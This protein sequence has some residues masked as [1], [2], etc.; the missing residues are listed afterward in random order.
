MEKV[1]RLKELEK[2]AVQVDKKTWYAIHDKHPD[3][4]FKITKG[5]RRK[6]K[7]LHD[8]TKDL[9]EAQAYLKLRANMTVDY[10]EYIAL[11]HSALT[12][13]D[14][15][16]THEAFLGLQKD[17]HDL[18]R[19]ILK[20]GQSQNPALRPYDRTAD[21][22][23]KIYEAIKARPAYQKAKE[24]LDALIK[25]HEEHEQFTNGVKEL[26]KESEKIAGS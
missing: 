8:F 10:T 23:E 11:S 1:P 4:V 21:I 15:Q 16:E 5:L 3:K 20:T 19:D 18:I 6:A 24:K 17:M 2:N 14:A 26:L 7:P 22:P 9:V 25:R 12:P 13:S